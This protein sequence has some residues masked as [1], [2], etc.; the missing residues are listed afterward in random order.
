MRVALRNL[1]LLSKAVVCPKEGDYQHESRNVLCFV[2]LKGEKIDH[3][4]KQ[5]ID[6]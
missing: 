2:E 4:A 3:A 6:T 1:G 5:I